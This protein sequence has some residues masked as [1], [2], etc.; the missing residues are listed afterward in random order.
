MTLL[1]NTHVSHQPLV[2]MRSLLQKRWAPVITSTDSFLIILSTISAG[3]W[4]SFLQALMDAVITSALPNRAA[5]TCSKTG[6]DRL[7]CQ[8]GME[9]CGN[10]PEAHIVQ[11]P[12]ADEIALP[13]C[14]LTKPSWKVLYFKNAVGVLQPFIKST[15][16]FT[17]GS[18][19]DPA[20]GWC[21][22]KIQRGTPWPYG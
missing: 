19:I 16:H 3:G 14:D 15:D 7:L 6:P 4:G 1:T 20:F 18:L 22:S 9:K 5:I 21:A 13:E 2:L 11:T 17:L 10:S 8:K 12:K